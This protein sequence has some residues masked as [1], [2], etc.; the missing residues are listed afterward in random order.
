MTAQPCFFC[1]DTTPD[2]RHYT[3]IVR[4]DGKLLGRLC[5]DGTAT[6]RKVHAAVLSRA[7][8]DQVAQAINDAGAFTAKVAPF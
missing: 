1:G 7:K 4:E 3:V 6:N 5:P 2:H 8:A